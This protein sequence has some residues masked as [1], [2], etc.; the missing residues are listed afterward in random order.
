MT[1]SQF[2]RVLGNAAS[3]ALVIVG[4][5]AIAIA[6][7]LGKVILAPVSFAIVIGLMFGP[8]ADIMEKRGLP[9]ALSAGVVVVL[10]IAV[11]AVAV[12]L[13]A[14]PLSEWVARGPL[15][16]EKVQAQLV[17]L[18]QPLETL[19]AVQEQ[20][21][22]LVGGDAQFTVDVQDGGPVQDVALMAPALMA[23]ILLFL[24]GLYFFMATRHQLRASMLSLC[25]SRR[26]RWR[27]AHVFRDVEVKVSKFLLS[28][29]MINTGV[30]IA[31]AAA[32][33]VLGMPSPLLWGALAGV[34]NFV[35][36]VGQA[37]MF[38][39]LF[40]VGLATQE[41]I[42]AALIPVAVYAAIN[43][44]AD[45]IV[46]PHFVGRAL[47]LN[48]FLIFVSIAFWI[49]IW[50]PIGGFV[51]VPSLLVL[52]SAIYHILPIRPERERTSSPARP[53]GG[54]GRGSA[55]AHSP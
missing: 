25:F 23:D 9:P 13:F 53:A 5:L 52:Q 14:A 31:T 7:V 39:V 37:V 34:L 33:S 46:F 16:W 18:R 35:P 4:M 12:A 22:G 20:L 36:Y 28:A 32:M 15:L 50:G 21:K 2:E 49:W 51:A 11:L 10:F 48:P 17:G 26:M 40:A 38:V 8:L 43:L 27:T 19:A 29:A 24:A 44:T 6:L 41:S 42:V 47:T 55:V 54:A 1:G 45:Q 3:F 30:G